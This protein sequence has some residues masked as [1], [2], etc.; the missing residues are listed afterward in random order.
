MSHPGVQAAAAIA[1]HHEKWDE[2]PIIIAV[3]ATD[4]AV[5]EQEILRHY[6]GK[7]ARWQIPDRVIFV[8]QLPLGSTGKVL[9]TD[10]RDRYFHALHKS[11][12][13]S[14]AP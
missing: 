1:A 7:V 12:A 14:A 5:A 11:D 4:A 9:K 8:D 13:G 10:L 2:R 6:E 3:K